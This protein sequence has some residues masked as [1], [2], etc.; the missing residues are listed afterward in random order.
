[1][2]EALPNEPAVEVGVKATQASWLPPSESWYDD[3]ARWNVFLAQSG[4]A[5]WPRVPI[6][7]TSPPRRPVPKT[8][9]TAVSQSNSTVSFHVSRIGTPILVKVSYFPNWQASGATG[10]YRVTPNLMVVVPTAHRVV[11]HYGADRAD[12]VG[13]ILTGVGLIALLA[14]VLLAW[15]RRRGGRHRK[16]RHSSAPKVVPS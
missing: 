15:V 8:R 1:V 10:P 2:V 12:Q 14:L 11:L 7:D 3:P 9:V 6:G 5:S 4:P 13:E 16:S